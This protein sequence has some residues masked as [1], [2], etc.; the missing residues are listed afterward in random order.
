MAIEL[1]NSELS[2]TWHSGA[3]IDYLDSI[4]AEKSQ[5]G[6]VE[7]VAHQSRPLLV[8]TF[9]T[10]DA[11]A[12]RAMFGT[13]RSGRKAF[14]IR[15]PIDAYKKVTAATLGT[16]TGLAQDFTLK[17][18][19]GTLEWDATYAVEST[20]IVYDNGTPISDSVWSW[21]APVLSLDAGAIAS[22]HTVTVTFEY[23]RKVHF[24]DFTLPDVVQTVDYETI[25]SMTLEEV[26]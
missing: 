2:V 26:F 25:Q 15:V 1:V 16:A 6:L 21:A 22:G 8:M 20:I 19:L 11:T 23:N 9:S 3:Q 7:P 10:N 12:A 13:T 4:V 18:A 24:A 14:L 5:G 17:I